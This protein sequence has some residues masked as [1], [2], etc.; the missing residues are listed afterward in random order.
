MTMTQSEAIALNT[1]LRCV[2][3]STEHATDPVAPYEAEA[4]L[5]TLL[6]GAHGKLGAGY[7]P[8]QATAL[9]ARMTAPK[10]PRA[11]RETDPL[12]TRPCRR[13]E[14]HDAHS[15]KSANDGRRFNVRCPGVTTG[16]GTLAATV[17]Q[18]TAMVSTLTAHGVEQ[19]AAKTGATTEAVE[20]A[21]TAQG[22]QLEQ[23]RAELD[24]ALDRIAPV[25]TAVA[26]ADSE[27]AAAQTA[28]PAYVVTTVAEAE[29]IPS[30]DMAVRV[31]PRADVDDDEP[32]PDPVA[33]YRSMGRAALRRLCSDLGLKVSG[34][35]D[36]LAQR[37]AAADRVIAANPDA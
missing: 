33:E 31:D 24:E 32:T 2:T 3:G 36:E 26:D 19:I 10:A 29:V 37:L 16:N 18:E 8:E 14:P 28:S 4:A 34:T 35:P 22:I 11:P 1:F 12:R 15:W 20:D 9:M 27:A 21:A 7:R 17:A 6:R 5:G 23:R 30:A 25:V 13:T